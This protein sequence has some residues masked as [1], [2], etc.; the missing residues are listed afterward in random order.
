MS[1]EFQEL[2]LKLHSTCIDSED[3]K[4]VVES[5]YEHRP[6]NTNQLQISNNEEI[7]IVLDWKNSKRTLLLYNLVKNDFVGRSEMT[8]EGHVFG[9]WDGKIVMFSS[10]GD[11]RKV[12]LTESNEQ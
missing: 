11:N 7:L 1:F 4:Y 8:E 10:D 12:L 6:A 3:T 5:L 9:V 2:I